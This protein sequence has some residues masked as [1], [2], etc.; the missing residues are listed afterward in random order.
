MGSLVWPLRHAMVC[1][2]RFRPAAA[3]AASH[4]HNPFRIADGISC[5]R[6]RSPSTQPFRTTHY[7]TTAT[8]APATKQV[9]INDI[10]SAEDFLAAVEE[11]LKGKDFNDGSLIEGT[12]VK[13]DRDEVRLDV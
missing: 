11:T 12:V 3:R 4:D 6:R 8:T 9:A 13:I 5:V 10:G 2:F 7:M 1:A